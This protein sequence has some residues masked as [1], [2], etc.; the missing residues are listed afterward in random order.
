MGDRHNHAL[1]GA[2]GCSRRQVRGSRSPYRRQSTIRPAARHFALRRAPDAAG[3]S[4]GTRARVRRRGAGARA[5]TQLPAAARRPPLYI[6]RGLPP[7]YLP[8]CGRR[9]SQSRAAGPTPRGLTAAPPS[10]TGRRGLS[11]SRFGLTMGLT[12]E[13]EEQRW[14]K[15]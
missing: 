13:K 6:G 11:N 4:C 9:G 2:D 1:A 14:S 15:Q 10:A 12:D 7:T 5:W 3:P 8:F